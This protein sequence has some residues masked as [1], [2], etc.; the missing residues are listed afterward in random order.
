MSGRPR[1]SSTRSN[2][3]GRRARRGRLRRRWP[4][5]PASPSPSTSEVEM[6]ASSSTSRM[7]TAQS[8]RH[9]R[10]DPASAG[11]GRRERDGS[12]TSLGCRWAGPSTA[13]PYR[14]INAHRPEGGPMKPTVATSLSLVAV[15]GAG[16]LAAAANFRVLAGP[17]EAA[18]ASLGRD[19]ARP[20]RSSR[21]TGRRRSPWRPAGTLTLDGT[22]GLHVVRIEPSPG[23][24]AAAPAGPGGHRRRR[25]RLV[26]RGHHRRHRRARCRRHPGGRPR[27]HHVRH[28][29]RRR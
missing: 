7:C 26:D 24:R 1:S 13:P 4:S 15:L 11:A 28:P 22:G 18:S 27:G 25:L 23:W 14:A 20:A 17:D 3:P 9:L 19:C 5:K 10:R 8:F 6:A 29:P 21:G 12:W 2:S 16:L